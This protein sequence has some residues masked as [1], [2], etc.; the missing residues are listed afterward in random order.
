MNISFQMNRESALA[1]VEA[2]APS[3][4]LFSQ[5]HAPSWRAFVNGQSTQIWKANYGFQAVVV[6][7]GRHRIELRYEDRLVLGGAIVSTLALVVCVAL[8]ARRS[9]SVTAK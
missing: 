1:E 7:A 5:A 8:L 6:P 2:A 4:V 3:V 9:T